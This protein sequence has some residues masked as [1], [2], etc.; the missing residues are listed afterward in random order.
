MK[1]AKDVQLGRLIPWVDFQLARLALAGAFAS[2]IGQ[3]STA[4]VADRFLNS[5]YTAF[6]ASG[7]CRADRLVAAYGLSR[8]QYKFLWRPPGPELLLP[9]S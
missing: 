6:G 3:V 8:F 2:T 9:L 4:R 1:V 5:V 7:V